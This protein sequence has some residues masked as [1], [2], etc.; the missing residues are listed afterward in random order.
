MHK[1]HPVWVDNNLIDETRK[2]K[3]G[4]YVQ[5]EFAQQLPLMNRGDIVRDLRDEVEAGS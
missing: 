2:F 5:V 3:D 1:I 4:S